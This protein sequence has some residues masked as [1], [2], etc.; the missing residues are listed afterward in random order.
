MEIFDATSA[1][2]VQNLPPG[3]NRVKVSKNLGETAVH[4][5][6]LQLHP[7]IV[8]FQT[9]SDIYFFNPCKN[10]GDFPNNEGNEYS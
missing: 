3:W 1:T 9:F 2:F 8:L 10:N 6:P 7:C 4:W 5:S